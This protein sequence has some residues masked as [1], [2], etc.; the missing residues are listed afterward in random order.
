MAML[1]SHCCLYCMEIVFLG[2][3]IRIEPPWEKV[4]IS[5]KTWRLSSWLKMKSLTFKEDAMKPQ[6]TYSPYMRMLTSLLGLKDEPVRILLFSTDGKMVETAR[7]QSYQNALPNR[8]MTF[9]FVFVASNLPHKHQRVWS[10]HLSLSKKAHFPKCWTVP[11]TTS[12]WSS[13]EQETMTL[14]FDLRSRMNRQA[15]FKNQHWWKKI[16][17][18][19]NF[20]SHIEK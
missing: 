17:I 20:L 13:P 1:Y 9:L 7:I 18:C 2:N 8:Y 15:Q 3:M 11:W 10:Y 4:P 16:Q 12:N 14:P 6:Q 5:P 19:V